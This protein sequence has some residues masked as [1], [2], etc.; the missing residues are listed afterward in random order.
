MNMKRIIFID[1]SYYVL[2]LHK[3]VTVNSS[4]M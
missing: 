2:H 1:R 4:N 3:T